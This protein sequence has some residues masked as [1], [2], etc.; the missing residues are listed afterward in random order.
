M[1]KQVE[2]E[3][4]SSQP[5]VS[6]WF[7]AGF[8]KLTGRH[9]TKRTSSGL[10]KPPFKQTLLF[11]ALEQRVLM[12]ADPLSV[13]V[14]AH[15]DGAI[16]TPGTLDQHSIT[17][18]TDTRVVFDSLSN[19]NRF[20][21]TLDGPNGRVVSNRAFTAS[22]SVELGAANPVLDLKAGTYN[23]TVAGSADATGN[24]SF[25]LIDLS[26]ATALTPGTT[27][28]NSLTPAN[29]SS[30]YKFDAIA[31]EHYFLDVTGRTGGDIAWQL[32][33]PSDHQVFA[34]TAMNSASQDVDL[35]SLASSGTYT[36]LVEGRIGATGTANYAFNSTSCR[37]QCRW[38]GGLPPLFQLLRL[39]QPSAGLAPRVRLVDGQQLE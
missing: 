27:V 31:G 12:A 11:E 6:S 15:V 30:V 10:T 21:W 18:A 39:R 20:N 8:D 9:R 34:P 25:Q 7:Q 38:P 35:A 2:S 17:L 26:K 23:A 5:D 4:V 22:D 13:F 24:Y 19:D 33:D 16:S 28:S 29:G 32:L 3:F 1:D 37:P 14:A 36:L